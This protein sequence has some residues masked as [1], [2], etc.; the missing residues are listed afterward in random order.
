MFMWT[1]ETQSRPKP[2]HCL[3][4]ELPIESL[5]PIL[6]FNPNFFKQSPPPRNKLNKGKCA[7][8]FVDLKLY[9]YTFFGPKNL[10][11]RY[12]SVS[13]AK[14]QAFLFCRRR[15]QGAV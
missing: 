4:L 1:N 14:H 9:E 12:F 13:P 10:L 15:A 11:V 3:H 8:I 6:I 5:T 2:P 7:Q